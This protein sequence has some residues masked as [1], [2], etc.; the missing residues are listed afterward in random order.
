MEDPP[1]R[2]RLKTP[3]Y[4][5]LCLAVTGFIVWTLNDALATG[6]IALR[7]HHM[8]SR[9]VNP[10]GFWLQFSL[11]GLVALASAIFAILLVL[12]PLLNRKGPRNGRPSDL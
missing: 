2:D 11:F 4:G 10:T 12:T 7:H 8:I 9:S 3:A 5:L 6:S 1:R